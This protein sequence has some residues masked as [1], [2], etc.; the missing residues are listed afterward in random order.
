[1]DALCGRD[2]PAVGSACTCI[3][4]P[5]FNDPNKLGKGDAMVQRLT[6]LI[7]IFQKPELDFNTDSHLAGDIYEDLLHFFS[8]KSGKGGI[9]PYTPVE[10]RQLMAKVLGIS[11]TRVAD[12]TVYDPTCGYGSLL[13]QVAKEA[14]CDVARYGQEINSA[15]SGLAQMNMIL[16]DAGTAEVANGNVLAE[17]RFLDNGDLKRFDYVVACPPFSLNH[18]SRGFD[19]E[20]DRFGRFS[21]GIPPKQQGDFAFIQHMLASLKAEGRMAV[22]I[23]HGVLFRG[24]TEATIRQALLEADFVEAVIGLPANLLPYTGIPVCILVCNKK[25]PKERANKVLI[26][27]ADRNFSK[28]GGNNV[29][30]PEHVAKIADAFEAYSDIER[31]SR[32]VSFDEMRDNAFNLNIPRYVDTSELA[33][34]LKQHCEQ[35]DKYLIKDLALEINTVR[36]GKEFEEKPNSLFISRMNTQMRRPTTDLYAIPANRHMHYFQVVLNERAINLS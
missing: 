27:N 22:L 33:A 3:D 8:N 20:H 23:S 32:V 35:F 9:V 12:V 11:K 5:D 18:W 34:L 26:I 24:K 7:S 21:F 1:M 10:V 17:P 29:L 4:F 30:L 13:L 16:H 15:V 6:N 25:K 19:P 2:Y 14:S 36:A 31:F 28:E